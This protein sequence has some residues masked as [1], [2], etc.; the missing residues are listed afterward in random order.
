MEAP[1]SRSRYGAQTASLLPSTAEAASLH[2]GW[3]EKFGKVVKYRGFMG[4]SRL[5]VTDPKA[6]QHILLNHSYEYPK[7]AQAREQMGTILC[8]APDTPIASAR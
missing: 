6:L 2:T 4:E 3:V 5:Y 7:P 8:V 1:C